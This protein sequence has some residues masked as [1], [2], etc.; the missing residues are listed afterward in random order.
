[1]TTALCETKRIF[2]LSDVIDKRA[3]ERIDLAFQIMLNGHVGETKNISSTG[4]YFEVITNDIEKFS[5]GTTVP[6]QI[7]AFTSTPGFEPR[8]IKL[9][10]NGF[11]VR[12]DIKN[13]S[14]HGNRLGVAMK[15]EKKLDLQMV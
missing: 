3:S 13:L 4:V 8:D 11:I 7:N 5:P 12:N 1:M 6:I 9:K 10:G 15:F 2:E 14:R